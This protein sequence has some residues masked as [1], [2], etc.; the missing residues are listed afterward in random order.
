M[1]SLLFYLRANLGSSSTAKTQ[2]PGSLL[3]IVFVLLTAFTPG[4]IYDAVE[5]ACFVLQVLLY[6]F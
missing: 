2:T 1:H 4:N 6:K 3:H 5:E